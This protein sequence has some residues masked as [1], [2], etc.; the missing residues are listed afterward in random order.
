LNKP[1]TVLSVGYAFAPVG[2]DAVGGAEQILSAID[3]A[4]VVAGH[5]SLVVAPEG[6]R[7]AGRLIA[8]APLPAQITDEARRRGEDRQ[9]Q[10]IEEAL[11]GWPVDVIHAHG[12]DFAEHLPD[13]NVPTLITL[14]LPVEFYSP[15][16]ISATRPNIWFNCVS[17]AQHRTFPP[18]LNMLDP[19]PNG[20]PFEALQARHGRRCFA[21]ALGRICPEKGLHLAIDAAADG[22]VPLLIAGEVFPD[23]AH[24]QYFARQIRPRLGSAARFLGPGDFARKRRLLTAARCLLVPSLA[25]ETSSLVAMEALACGCPVVAFPNGALPDILEPGVTGFLVSDAREMA[26]AIPACDEIDR[27][28]CREVAQRRF[29]LDAMI[30]RYFALYRRLARRTPSPLRKRGARASEELVAPDSRFRGNDEV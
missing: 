24:R 1:F 14:H 3:R 18:G 26:E 27:A 20:V 5:L 13:S 7:I 17:A 12:L 22:G 4:L 15:G 9:R 28:V 29:S 2:A 10:A 8:T 19:I 16:A 21:L 30:E 23:Q 11:A 25:A 6:S